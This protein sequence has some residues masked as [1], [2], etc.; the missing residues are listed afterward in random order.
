[1]V[2][3]CLVGGGCLRDCG[4]CT[5]GASTITSVMVYYGKP[6]LSLPQKFII[7]P[8]FLIKLFS[9]V[10]FTYNPSSDLGSL[11]PTLNPPSTNAKLV[12]YQPFV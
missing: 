4:V 2:S 1:M 7:S 6:L 12:L 3:W 8:A 11:L 9:A 10:Y 5:V